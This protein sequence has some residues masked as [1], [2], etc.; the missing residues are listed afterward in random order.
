MR[1]L[2]FTI[3]SLSLITVLAAAA[4]SP[5]LGLIAQH[6]SDADPL[7]IKLIVTLPGLSIIVSSLLVNLVIKKYESKRVA[8]L[9]LILFT[10]GSAAGLVNNI[11]VMLVFRILLGAGVGLVMPLSTALIALYIDGKEHARLIGHSVAINNLGGVIGTLLSGL[12]ISFHWRHTFAIY[13][14]GLVIIVMV[15]LFLPKAEIKRT[16]NGIPKQMLKAISP[17]L[18]SMFV[19]MVVLCV[20]PASF[21]MIAT[22]YA[23]VPA[24]VI[25]V[26]MSTMNLAAFL[27]GLI[28]ARIVDFTRKYTQLFAGLLFVVSFLTM[29]ATGSVVLSTLGLFGVGA[30]IGVMVSVLQSQIARRASKEYV[31]AAMA[32]TTAVIYFGQF[33]SPILIEAIQAL[34]HW[35]DARTPYYLAAALS[36][37]LMISYRKVPI[38]PAHAEVMDPHD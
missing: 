31:T 21:S 13:L 12:L 24:A 2:K 30:G 16:T 14:L 15:V 36:V 19:V 1:K 29:S 11:Y 37:L 23:L 9:G 33:I 8:L 26:L 3:L 18:L 7:L 22:H 17:H 5:A 6:F 27:T 28:A 10:A 38:T 25:G 34:F 4:V 35:Q 20:V 32:I